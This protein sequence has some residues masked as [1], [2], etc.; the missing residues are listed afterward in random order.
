ML[1]FDFDDLEDLE[2]GTFTSR[3]WTSQKGRVQ[4]PG[5]FA[6]EWPAVLDSERGQKGASI[7]LQPP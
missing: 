4:A 6:G 7:P 5:A 3:G 2:D 1:C